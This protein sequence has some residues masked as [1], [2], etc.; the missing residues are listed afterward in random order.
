VLS[1]FEMIRALLLASFVCIAA[2]AESK[3][4]PLLRNRDAQ[5]A[6]AIFPASL[7]PP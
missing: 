3:R 6:A 2:Q 4:A 5:L 1:R 7:S